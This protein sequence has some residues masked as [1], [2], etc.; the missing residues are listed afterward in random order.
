MEESITSDFDLKKG[1]CLDLHFSLIDPKSHSMNAFVFN[2]CEKSVILA[3]REL[4]KYIDY[5]LDI[6]VFAKDEGG[7]IGRYWIKI[8]PK[9]KASAPYAAT[10]M[11]ILVTAWANNWFTP[12][13]PVQKQILDKIEIVDK[14]KT[15]KI[16]QDEFDYIAEGDSEL[17]KL[18]NNFFNNSIKEENITEVEV[19]INN[20]RTIKL[21]SSDFD[22]QISRFETRIETITKEG[23]SVYIVSPILIKV[24]NSKAKWR[25]I[26][27][28]DLIEFSLKDQEFLKSVENKDV[29]FGSGTKIKCSLQITLKTSYNEYGEEYEKISYSVKEVYEA[30]DEDIYDT[31]IK[32]FKKKREPKES[33]TPS[34]FT[35]NEM[36][37]S[38]DAN[39]VDSQ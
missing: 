9:V 12:K 11:G 22:R 23:V 32:K 28:G 16:T 31:G 39:S 5:E 35:Q 25:G 20:K 2:E 37:G 6:D 36:S 13:D 38:S 14:I 10:I 15:G 8:K 24:P 29:K 26:Y 21:Q 18:K 27:L 7:V 1:M 3:L 17:K 4:Q 34:L 30:E 33:N 19:G